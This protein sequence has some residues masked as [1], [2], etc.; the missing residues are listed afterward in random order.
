MSMSDCSRC[1][2]TPCVCGYDYKDRPNEYIID[3]YKMFKKLLAERGISPED[4]KRR[5]Y[6]IKVK[7]THVKPDKPKEHVPKHRNIITI[8]QN[9]VKSKVKISPPKEI[10]QEYYIQIHQTFEY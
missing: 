10:D 4:I 8:K 6:R 2:E 1:W 3:M 7:P 5:D 9:T